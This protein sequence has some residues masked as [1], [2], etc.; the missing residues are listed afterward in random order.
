MRGLGVWRG[1]AGIRRRGTLK[2]KVKILLFTAGEMGGG[3]EF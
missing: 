1:K 2:A 3:L